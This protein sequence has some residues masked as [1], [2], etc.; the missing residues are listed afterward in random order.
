MLT[1]ASPGGVAIIEVRGSLAAACDVLDSPLPAVGEI[2]LARECPI[3]ELLIARLESDRLHLMPHGGSQIVSRV[4]RALETAGFGSIDAIPSW[5]HAQD[6]IEARV[7]ACV[8]EAST[9]LALEL[10]LAQPARWQSFTDSWT[11]EDEARS[12]RLNCFA[13]PTN[14]GGCGPA[15]YRKEHA[16]QHASRPRTCRRW[17]HAWHNPRLGWRDR[18]S[19]WAHRALDGRARHHAGAPPMQP[20][21]PP[22]IR[23]STQFKRLTYSLPPPTLAVDGS[24]CIEH[25]TCVWDSAGTLARYKMPTCSAPPSPVRA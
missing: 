18:R 12:L 16:A 8:P 10:L 20:S 1:A 2:H 25:Q 21:P 4:M 7:M 15:Q 22:L 11:D 13:Q 19:C 3:D 9:P 17:R 23:R 6:D 24:R 5:P 14:C